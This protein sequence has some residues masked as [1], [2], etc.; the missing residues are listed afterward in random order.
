MKIT[1]P[2]KLRRA[3]ALGAIASGA[4]VACNKGNTT[5]D[6]PIPTRDVEL[7]FDC[8]YNNLSLKDVKKYADMPDVRYIYMIPK[9]PSWSQN[10]IKGIHNAKDSLQLRF[11]INP[12]KVRAK[13]TFEFKSGEPSKN[14]A[15]SL[16]F[17]QKGWT[18]KP[19]KQR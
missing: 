19:Y 9:N 7:V 10:T 6:T 2:Y 1:I 15:D 8:Y 14:I 3:L 5:H 16:W 13:G 18:I 12:E 11:D 17:I 4:L